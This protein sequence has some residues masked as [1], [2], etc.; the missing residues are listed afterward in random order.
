VTGFS[1]IWTSLPT[2]AS[3]Q[4]RLAHRT[5]LSILHEV[6]RDDSEPDVLN[7]P[8][9]IGPKRIRG[10]ATPR[11]LA[12]KPPEVPAAVVMDLLETALRSLDSAQ[13]GRIY[14]PHFTQQMPVSAEFGAAIEKLNTLSRAIRRWL[15]DHRPLKDVGEKRGAALGPHESVGLLIVM[16]ILRCGQCSPFVIQGII[17]ALA[18]SRRPL[19]VG[20]WTW[21]DIPLGESPQASAQ[22]RRIFMD[23]ATLAAWTWAWAHRGEVPD[24]SSITRAADRRKFLQAFANHAV[25]ALCDRISKDAGISLE[26]WTVRS[27]CAAREDALRL[28]T[29]PVLASYAAGRFAS[30]S[31]TEDTWLRFLNVQR[32]TVDNELSKNEAGGA[33]GLTSLPTPDEENPDWSEIVISGEL[34]DDG[35]MADLRRAMKLERSKWAGEFDKL[36]ETLRASG[37]NDYSTSILSIRWLRHLSEDRSSKGKLLADGSIRHYRGLLIARLIETFPETLSGMDGD[38]LTDLY[39][40]V[41]SDTLSPQLKGRVLG[42]LRE[43]DRFVRKECL[44]QLPAASIPGFDG[45]PYEISARIITVAEFKACI[46]GIES[47]ELVQVRTQRERDR[48]QG[49]LM[50]AFRTGGRRNELLGLRRQDFWVQDNLLVRIRPNIVRKLKTSNARRNIPLGWIP[51]HERE[52][53]EA[54]SA[55]SIHPEDTFVFFDEACPSAVALENHRIISLARLVLKEVSGDSNLHPHNIRHSLASLAAAGMFGRDLSVDA[56]P[57]C[58]QWILEAMSFAPELEESISSHLHRSAARGSALAM[59]LGHGSE[60]TSYEHYVHVFDLLLFLAIDKTVERDTTAGEPTFDRGEAELI[61]ALLG[62]SAT[63]RLRT[64]RLESGLDAIIRRLPKGDIETLDPRA[65]APPDPI[66][67]STLLSRSESSA[68]G[69]P[70]QPAEL[71]TARKTLALILGWRAIDKGLTDTLIRGLRVRKLKNSTWSSFDPFSA[72]NILSQL[73][74]LADCSQHIEVKWVFVT[75]GKEDNV[76][77]LLGFEEALRRSAVDIGNYWIRIKDP[78]REPGAKRQREQDVV[79]WCVEHLAMEIDST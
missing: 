25:R 10:L 52:R 16:L 41:A 35:L 32:P 29:L 54:L 8:E 68:A 62:N 70:V 46:E 48:L 22:M 47:G 27:L 38:E 18:Q 34:D 2:D 66:R 73:R 13:S 7:C 58:P 63:T 30:S 74:R 56:H 40:D 12:L 42:A 1:T 72:N 75:R 39:R 57:M 61:S 23:S 53:L 67:L 26:K 45:G 79:S 60:I 19:R 65:P 36:I 76:R 71:K 3:E 78:R 31:L 24:T 6:A 4:H 33:T 77:E 69:R 51:G 20:P 55:K 5:L 21:I 15:I 49:F 11:I 64:A 28:D 14:A 50:L 43:F 17:E 37:H 44:P 59:L 9:K